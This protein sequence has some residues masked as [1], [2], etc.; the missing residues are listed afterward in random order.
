M[1]FASQLCFS[2]IRYLYITCEYNY[3]RVLPITR[4]GRV[5]WCDHHSIA[6]CTYWA[7]LKGLEIHGARNY[8]IAQ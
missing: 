7:I 1:L 6:N 3:K 5:S 8:A 4:H 2:N